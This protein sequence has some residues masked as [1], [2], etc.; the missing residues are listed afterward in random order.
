ML[1]IQNKQKRQWIVAAMFKP[2]GSAAYEHITLEP[3]ESKPIEEDHWNF[4][5]KGNPVI[6]ALLTGRHL[7]VSK[8]KKAGIEADEL[9]NP[10]SPEAPAELTD[11]DPRAKIE[12]KVE[13]KEI[14]LDEP[15][16]GKGKK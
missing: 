15:A 3:G 6:E 1:M 4:V 14:D 12:S 7:V 10:A 16:Q 9:A 2:D 13:L 11:E 8:V 5:S